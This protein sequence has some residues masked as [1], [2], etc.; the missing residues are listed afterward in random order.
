MQ[1]FSVLVILLLIQVCLPP[2]TS[3]RVR[4]IGQHRHHRRHGH[5]GLNRQSKNEEGVHLSGDA[6]TVS[7]HSIQAASDVLMINRYSEPEEK[8]EF[9][10]SI[11]DTSTLSTGSGPNPGGN[12]EILAESSGPNPGGNT[13]ILVAVSDSNTGGNTNLAAVSG[14]NPGGNADI[15]YGE[16]CLNPGGNLRTF[17]GNANI[18]GASSGPNPGGNANILAA[19]SGPNPAGNTQS[20]PAS[21]RNLVEMRDVQSIVT[22]KQDLHITKFND[23]PLTTAEDLSGSRAQPSSSSDPGFPTAAGQM[24]S[25]S[26]LPQGSTT[27]SG[28]SPGTNVISTQRDLQSF[29]EEPNLENL[30]AGTAVSSAGKVGLQEAENDGGYIQCRQRDVLHLCENG[31]LISPELLQHDILSKESSTIEEMFQKSIKMGTAVVHETF[32]SNQNRAP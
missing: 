30:R 23:Q 22:E 9:D 5:L 11:L 31:I 32:L 12:S 19:S 8:K 25:F 10:L 24:F 1:V 4:F 3:K 2:A 13:E 20:L 21:S 7:G 6:R 29:L 18:L 27:P 14:P 26:I 15:L 17:G 16:S 28:P